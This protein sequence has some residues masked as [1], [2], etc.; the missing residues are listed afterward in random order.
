[1]FMERK[2]EQRGSDFHPECKE[3]RFNH[4]AFADDL[5]LITAATRGSF[6]V[7]KEV[8]MEFGDLEGLVPNLNKFSVY[9]AAVENER[10]NESCEITKMPRG[11]LPVKYLGLPLISSITYL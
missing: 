8:I 9:F 10:S 6:E 11:F 5:F 2:I 7:I 4:I 1:M 3:L